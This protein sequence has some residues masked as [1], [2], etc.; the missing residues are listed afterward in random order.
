VQRDVTLQV[1][2]LEE[3]ITILGGRALSTAATPTPRPAV[4]PQLV[5][6]GSAECRP[7]PAGG[8][9]RPPRK[10][11]DRKPRYPEQLEAENVGGSVVLNARIGTDGLV[12]EVDIVKTDHPDLAAAAIEAVRQWEFSSTLLN[13]V[14]VEVPMQ[15]TARFRTEP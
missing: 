4:N 8:K 15:V 6:A 11:V 2:S 9:I 13:C 7:T 1:G 5:K 3:T 10:L 14:P 12:K